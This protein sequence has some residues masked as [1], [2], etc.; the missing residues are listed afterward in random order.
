MEHTKKMI[1]VEPRQLEKLKES[2]LDKTLSKLDGEIYE[3]LHTN[4]AD[5]EKAKLYSNSLSRYLN[6]DKPS[7]VTKF[8]LNDNLKEVTTKESKSI[9]SMLLDTVSKK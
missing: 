9:E 6:L 7:I 4:M 5:D 8:T 2:M 3:I 1:L